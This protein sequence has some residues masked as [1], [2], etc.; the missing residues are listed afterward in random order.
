MSNIPEGIKYTK[1][2]EW[3][4]MEDDYTG[5]CGITDHAQDMLS[6][7]LYIELSSSGMEVRQDEQVSVLESDKAISKV[8][9]PVSG[10]IIEVNMLLEGSPGLIN[11]DPYGDGWIFRIELKDKYELDYLMSA[12][13]YDAYIEAG[14]K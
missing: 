10:R 8:Y 6:F 14:E 5:M 2:H 9:A 13:E 1:T 4:R 11:K 12:E 3:I 7:I